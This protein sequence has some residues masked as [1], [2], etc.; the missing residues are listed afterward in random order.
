MARLSEAQERREPPR[1]LYH[2]VKML[3]CKG[4]FTKPSM[5][6]L[7]EAQERRKPQELYEVKLPR[8]L[9]H[10]CGP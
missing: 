7:C 1:I 2:E 4:I 8:I 5:V 6:R 9:Y 10:I 3:A